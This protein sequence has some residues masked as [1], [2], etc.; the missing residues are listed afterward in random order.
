MN[1]FGRNSKLA[2][3]RRSKVVETPFGKHRLVA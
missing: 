2:T 1:S 3:L